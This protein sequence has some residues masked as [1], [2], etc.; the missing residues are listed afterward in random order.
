M[1]WKNFSSF[2]TT[3]QSREKKGIYIINQG[4]KKTAV[5]EFSQ[6]VCYFL[7]D[8]VLQET[9]LGDDPKP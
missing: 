4:N 9:Q 5:Y 8:T 2:W 7:L 3:F 1:E 6:R